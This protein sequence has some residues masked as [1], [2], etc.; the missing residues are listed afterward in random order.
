ME[1]NRLT[2]ADK[3]LSAAFQLELKG[4]RP[5]PIEDLVVSAW[6][7]FPDAFSLAGHKLPD[8]NR[9]FAEVM[10]SKP[11][12]QQGLI[13]KVGQKM[14]R[15]SEAG[16][17]RARRISNRTNGRADAKMALARPT[18]DRLRKVLSTRAVEKC[19]DGKLEDISFYEACAF[20]GIS[21]R[22]TAIEL[23][24]SINN[25]RR[26]LDA[27]RKAL[28]GE[29]RSLQHGGEPI[30]DADLDLVKQL[31]EDLQERY[32]RELDVIRKRTDERIF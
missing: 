2:I 6:Q 28:S 4:K 30:G 5:F 21:P 20:W 26:I 7:M 31:D 24:G 14:Y 3:V 11:L 8:S 10:G 9:V 23:E 32:K 15:L 29:D 22:S 1:I 18:I 17:E 19:R 12:R 25:L 13:V 16:L 27:A